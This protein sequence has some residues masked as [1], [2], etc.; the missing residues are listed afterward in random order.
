MATSRSTPAD[1]GVND[2]VLRSWAEAARERGALQHLR[3]IFLYSQLGVTKWSLPHL[4][5]FPNLD[6]FC[7][8]DCGIQWTD[9]EHRHGWR[10]KPE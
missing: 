4:D 6:E 2:R 1:V 5:A 9:V 7:A 8:Y 3:F 10:R